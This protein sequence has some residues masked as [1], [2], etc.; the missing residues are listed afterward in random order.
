MKKLEKILN[1]KN[2]E[3]YD[4][5]EDGFIGRYYDS[6]TNKW[7][8]FVFS[9]GM[10]WEHLSVSM[11]SRTPTW[12][13]MCTMK[14]IFFEEEEVCVEYHPKK[15]EYVNNHS[16]CLHIWKPINSKLPVPESI[17]VGLKGIELC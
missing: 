1:A 2:L 10:G 8:T 3:I 9:W 14:D 15:S 16:H 13:Q 7:L 4:Q 12:E 6:R 11:P 5:G 17:L